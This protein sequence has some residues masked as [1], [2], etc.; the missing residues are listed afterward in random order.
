MKIKKFLNSNLGKVVTVVLGCLFVILLWSII[1]LSLNSSL[2]PGP[3]PSFSKLFSFFQTDTFYFALGGTMF[4]LIVSLGISFVISLL[5]GILG[6]I[7]NI[8]HRFISPLII[9][10]RTLP[11]A[12]VLFILVV[13]L[14]P[15][16]A[17]YII[18]CMIMIPIMY[19][20]F[21]HGINSIS[22]N[23]FDSVRLDSNLKSKNSI[24]KIMVPLSSGSIVLGIVQSLGLGM[25]VSL[26]SEVIIGSD[27]IYGLGRL[28][29]K[30]YVLVDMESIFAISLISIIII[31]IFDILV[32]IIKNKIHQE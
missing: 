16:Y 14:K 21:R 22:P 20:A 4:R 27:K 32:R 3:I 31:G 11:V 26:M 17:L 9:A 6:G 10:I 28:I 8:F 19:E 1:S 5:L 15:Q 23:I 29:Y 12:A 2:F 25:K 24:F 30:A 18:N 7:S 13:I